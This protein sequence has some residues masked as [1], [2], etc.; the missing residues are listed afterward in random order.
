MLESL[1]EWMGYPLYYAFD[2]AAP[3]PRCGASH[4]SIYPY[5]PFQAGDGGTV[6]LGLQNEREW[7]Q[8]CERA[9]QNAALANDPRFDSNARRN[10]HREA[11]KAIILDAFAKLSTEQVLAR[12]DQAQIANARMSDMAG[13]WAHPQLQA[14]ERWQTVGSPAGDIPALLPPGRS[15]AFDYRMDPVPAVGQHTEAILRELGQ[16][17]ADIASLRATGAI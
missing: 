6:M 11:L 17:E 7:K 16:D 4:A 5:G 14:R 3:P 15:S 10:E 1:G 9:L 13:L 8:F 2:G 12:L